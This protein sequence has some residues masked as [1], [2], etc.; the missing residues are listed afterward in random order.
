MPVDMFMKMNGEKQ[1]EIK[2]ESRDKKHKGEIDVIAWSWGLTAPTDASPNRTTSGRIQFQHFTFK[3]YIDKASTKLLSS[4]ITNETIKSAVLTC[5]REGTSGGDPV[6]F[7]IIKFEDSRVVRMSRNEEAG[8]VNLFEE[9]TI[10]FQKFTEDYEE[11]T[12]EGAIG[13]KVS[14]NWSIADNTR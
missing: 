2:G 13:D 10:S 9:I 3:K 7:L 5:R 11:R 14:T 4:A 6:E 8:D 1:G 12:Q